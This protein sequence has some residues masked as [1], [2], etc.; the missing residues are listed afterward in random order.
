MK[1]NTFKSLV[2]DLKE[3]FINVIEY[4]DVLKVKSK[5]VLLFIQAGEG[6][7]PVSTC[8]NW[9]VAGSVIQPEPATVIA[10]NRNQ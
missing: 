5:A 6:T 1:Q 3:Y 7:F 2:L 9:V 4:E 8:V 10:C